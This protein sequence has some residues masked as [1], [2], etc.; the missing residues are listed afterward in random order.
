MADED[1]VIHGVE[2]EGQNRA[3]QSE[4]EDQTDKEMKMEVTEEGGSETTNN[5]CQVQVQCAGPS[6]QQVFAWN[7][8]KM[9][10]AFWIQYSFRCEWVIA[11]IQYYWCSLRT[12]YVTYIHWLTNLC[13]DTRPLQTKLLDWN[14]IPIH[15][16]MPVK[17]I[18]LYYYDTTFDIWLD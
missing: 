9:S 6:W 14:S 5:L 17:W 13:S 18:F 15:P 7:S 4:K 3:T 1:G 12:T 10:L 11:R 2:A 8:I 16:C